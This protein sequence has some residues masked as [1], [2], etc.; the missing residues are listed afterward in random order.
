[1]ADSGP[2]N[3]NLL[4]FV[5]GTKTVTDAA[6][7]MAVVVNGYL[8]ASATTIRID[9]S[10]VR[11]VPSSFFNLLLV[12]VA[13]SSGLESLDRLDFVT[14]TLVQRAVLDRSLQAIRDSRKAG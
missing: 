10:D 12:R 9:L 3:L 8:E 11:G 4:E 14:S 1:M 7:Q 2:V 6:E 13:D 5:D